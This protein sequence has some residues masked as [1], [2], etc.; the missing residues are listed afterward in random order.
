MIKKT[1][2]YKPQ[3]LSPAGSFACGYYAFEAGADAVYCGLQDF[4]ARKSA[5]NFTFEEVCTLKQIAA[6]KNRKIYIT[7]NTIIKDHELPKLFETLYQLQTMQIN[8]IIIQDP[9]LLAPLRRYFPDLPVHASTQMGIA[10]TQGLFCVKKLG[11]NRVILPRELSLQTITN[12]RNQVPDM[13]LETFIHGALCYSFSGY[14]LA[15]GLLLNRSGNRGECGQI[16]RTFFFNSKQQ[17]GYFFSCNDYALL[18]S[19]IELMAAGV[20][21]FKIEGRMK[22][23]EYVYYSSQLYRFIIDQAS[24]ALGQKS[25]QSITNSQLQTIA[26]NICESATFQELYTNSLL[27]FSRKQTKAYFFNDKAENLVDNAFPAHR[28]IEAGT[29]VSAENGTILANLKEPLGIRDGLMVL[30]EKP[31]KEAFCFSVRQL[32]LRKKQIHFYKPGNRQHESVAITPQTDKPKL[33]SAIHT[34]QILY[35]ISSRDLDLKDVKPDRFKQFKRPLDLAIHI[36][37]CQ[38]ETSFPQS[39]IFSITTSLLRK[40]CFFSAQTELFPAK[41]TDSFATHIKTLFAESGTGTF[42]AGSISITAAQP[43]SI[44]ELFVPPSKLKTIKNRFYEQ[45]NS[46]YTDQKGVFIDSM[47]QEPL[48]CGNSV[49]P[50]N[51]PLVNL[52]AFSSRTQL[53][54]KKFHQQL[55]FASLAD[56]DSIENLST[57]D[58]YTVIPLHPVI[59]G[60]DTYRL[61]V[62]RLVAAYPKKRFL[63]G[64]NN[65]A[66][67]ELAQSFTARKN[68]FFCIDFYAYTANRFTFYFYISQLH[69]ILFVYYWIEGNE[70][71]FTALKTICAGY[72]VPLVRI[73]PSFSAPLFLSR[74]CYFRHNRGAGEC[75]K[76]CQGHQEEIISSSGKKYLVMTDECVTYVFLL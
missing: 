2:S 34:G 60:W 65:M 23:P 63:L 22:S 61:A 36:A 4:S 15:S 5:V 57:V 70:K 11:I 42:S 1:S 13:E 43:L 72:P 47:V 14:C 17:K 37:P 31:S 53:S 21:A 27:T 41:K 64:I 45:V 76:G 18:T 8:G 32:H 38:Q 66:H 51:L 35:K 58:G 3:L 39:A 50:L 16:C 69:N 62:I 44:R 55:P 19:I 24:L 10:S 40:Q 74:G 75:L 20:D 49:A 6:E 25:H 67:L 9:G 29:V 46:F 33:I 59:A 12:L 56:L 52:A 48:Q 30:L 71:D 7:I 26:V 54:P 28:G 68:L 73:D